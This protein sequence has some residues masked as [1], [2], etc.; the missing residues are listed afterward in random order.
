[1]R[2]RVI[3]PLVKSG[4]ID[5][6]ESVNAIHFLMFYLKDNM[7][8][9][10]RVENQHS[11]L[12]LD[13]LGVSEIPRKWVQGAISSMSANYKCQGYKTYILQTV[14]AVRFLWA[15]LSPFVDEKIKRRLIFNKTSVCE[16]IVQAFHPS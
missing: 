10:G 2:P 4:E 1:M 7:L 16:E 6:E 15:V 8:I 13:F 11:I 3:V 14:T 5:L 9:P 12:D